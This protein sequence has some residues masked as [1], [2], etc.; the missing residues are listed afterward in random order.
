MWR[1]PS[2]PGTSTSH[3]LCER[4]PKRSSAASVVLGQGSN[5]PR[6]TS[7]RSSN[8]R[9]A[10]KEV[11]E[12]TVEGRGRRLRAKAAAADAFA[13]IDLVVEKL[14]HQLQSAR[15]PR[16]WPGATPL[17]RAVVARRRADEA[18]TGSRRR[19]AAGYARGAMADDDRGRATSPDD[20]IRVV[21]CDDHA[22][23]RRGLTMVL[24]DE[25]G[26]RGRRR[27]R[28]RRRRRRRR[29]RSWPPTS[30]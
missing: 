1:S 30:C 9:I 7:S 19:R 14:A 29:P 17:P 27:G 20:A 16:S 5:G 25:D 12:V 2:A 26:H 21:I 4:R 18:L 22:L 13:A 3:L 6:C 24:E 28:G 11:C 8:P 15:R 23:F 10:A